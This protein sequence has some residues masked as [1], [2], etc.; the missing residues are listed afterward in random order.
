MASDPCLESAIAECAR[1][2]ERPYYDVAADARSRDDFWRGIDPAAPDLFAAVSDRLL[3]THGPRLDYRPAVHLYP[4]VD[5]RPGDPPTVQSIYSGRAF[6]PRELIEADF[7]TEAERARLVGHLVDAPG[8]LS[9]D[10]ALRTIEAAL[11]YNCEHVVPQSWFARRHP[12]RGDLHHLFA[13]EIRCNEFRGRIPYHDF[14]EALGPTRTDC[15]RAEPNRFEPVAG[16][17]AVAR[18]TLYFLLRYPGEIDRTVIEYEEEGLS[19]LLAWHARHPADAYER[20]RNAAIQVKQGN[21]NPLIDF[22]EWADRIDF[23]RGLAPPPIA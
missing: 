9:Q 21:R 23:A 11:R 2:T 14:P 13:C 8:G 5:L 7:R 20:H 19:T 6:D 16:K 10:A 17:G 3:R 4:W 1:A 22:P 12:M 18:A 15:G